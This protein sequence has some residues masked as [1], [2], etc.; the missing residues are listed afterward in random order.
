VSCL[1]LPS[2]SRT[3]L[4]DLFRLYVHFMPSMPIQDGL[5]RVPPLRHKLAQITSTDG[6]ATREC[7]CRIASSFKSSSGK[8]LH[9]LTGR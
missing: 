5:Q 4:I 6:S 2:D 9:S 8:R 7:V 1:A 3:K